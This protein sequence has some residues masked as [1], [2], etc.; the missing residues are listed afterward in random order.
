MNFKAF[1]QML[2]VGALS[3]AAASAWAQR[4]ASVEGPAQL[5]AGAVI[6]VKWTG[7]P[8]GPR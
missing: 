5:P 1:Y 8:C 7:P 6:E 4:P 3:L 2:W